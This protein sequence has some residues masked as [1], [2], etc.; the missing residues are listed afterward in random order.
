MFTENCRFNR[1]GVI[2]AVALLFSSN[3]AAQ[4]NRPGKEA[5]TP[6]STES[7]VIFYEGFDVPDGARHTSPYLQTGANSYIFANPLLLYPTPIPT[8]AW[9]SNATE[10]QKTA[11]DLQND[12]YAVVSPK[13]IMNSVRLVEPSHTPFWNSWTSLINHGKDADGNVNGGAMV[14]NAGTTPGVLYDRGVILQRDKFYKLTYDI[15]IENSPSWLRLNFLYQNSSG[16]RIGLGEYLDGGHWSSDRRWKTQT[17]Y[18]SLPA[19]AC[20]NQ[21]YVITLQNHWMANNGNDFALDNIRLV[22][23]TGNPG[24][25]V[26]TIKTACD[27]PP[28][29]DDDMSQGNNRNAGNGVVTV[30]YIQGDYLANLQPATTNTV[31]FSFVVP[32]GGSLNSNRDEVTV[33][34]EGRWKLNNNGTVTFT[35]VSGFLGNPKP[36]QYTITENSTQMTSAPATISVLYTFLVNPSAADD[37]YAVDPSV[38]NT[39]YRADIFANDKI[40]G[41]PASNT[42]TIVEVVH[43]LNQ[44]AVYRQTTAQGLPPIAV[45]GEG[46]WTY[47]VSTGVFVFSPQAGYVES[48][49]PLYYRYQEPANKVWSNW[50]GIFF[51][52]S[53]IILPVEIK[54]FRGMF[55]NS[56]VTLNW[57]A[58]AEIN[59]VG[60]YVER[61]NDGIYWTT[62]GFVNTLSEQG[63]STKDYQFKDNQPETGVNYYRLKH[64]DVNN[65]LTYSKI[66]SLRTTAVLINGVYPNPADQF[67]NIS[68][69]TVG[70][71]TVSL[72]NISGQI[73]QQHVVNVTHSHQLFT[74]QRNNEKAGLYYVKITDATGNA[75]ITKLIFR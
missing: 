75:S 29:A 48:P 34:G 44:G 12:H 65:K 28:V 33:L 57:N 50:A 10:W 70:R 17:V 47:E 21:D 63:S 38:T 39:A 67:A 9:T 71:Y 26:T 25:S 49:T 55:V 30:N 36:V 46:V 4:L 53:T 23:L 66:I 7:R 62:V 41:N 58:T 11:K 35:P 20:V 69:S 3:L 73:V 2:T 6:N 16:A 27:V 43:P 72:I 68:I 22:E 42:G 54:D 24:G 31:K 8:G 18:F 13:D 14:V 59:S 19:S 5:V 74:L 45:P 40:D 15:W 60:Y 37:I 32:E 64:K 1:Y 61:S 51:N 56:N 52:A